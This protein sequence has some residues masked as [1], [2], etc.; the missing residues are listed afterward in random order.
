M[1]GST[2]RRRHGGE[3]G[4][5]DLRVSS[6]M[7]FGRG[8]PL[9]GADDTRRDGRT[10]RSGLAIMTRGC[11]RHPGATAVA[12]G[13]ALV[14]GNTMV[15]AAKAVGWSTEHLVIASFRE[16]RFLVGAAV[17]GAGSSKKSL[18]SPRLQADSLG[19]PARPADRRS[20]VTLT[21]VG[22]RTSGAEETDPVR[23]EERRERAKREG[24]AAPGRRR[25][26]SRGWVRRRGRRRPARRSC[27]GRPDHRWRRRP[28]CPGWRP[29]S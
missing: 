24:P 17:F 19:G 28:R 22:L 7:S 15:L 8:A 5:I 20:K 10:L 18:R 12:V 23:P 1:L 11:L 14:N 16:D 25:R 4:Q 13:S 3:R 9:A 26:G 29:A 21:P 6:P 2:I 27:P